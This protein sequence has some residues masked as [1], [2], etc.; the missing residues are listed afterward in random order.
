MGVVKG[1]TLMRK[2]YLKDI[3][4]LD[5]YTNR[6]LEIYIQIDKKGLKLREISLEDKEIYSDYEITTSWQQL[7]IDGTMKTILVVKK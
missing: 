1:A 5:K 2:V 7:R 4:D 6:D 3:V